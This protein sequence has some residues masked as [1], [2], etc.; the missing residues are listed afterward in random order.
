MDIGNRDPQPVYATHDGNVFR[1][2]DSG[3]GF[4]NYVEVFSSTYTTRYAHLEAFSSCLKALPNNTIIKAGTY[5]GTTGWTGYVIPARPDRRHLHYHI[6]DHVGRDVPIAEFN[7]LVPEPY[8]YGKQVTVNYSGS[9]CI[10]G[11]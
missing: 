3:D 2:P 11:P 9:G 6:F 5:L 10:L 8:T 1:H 7:S 4:G